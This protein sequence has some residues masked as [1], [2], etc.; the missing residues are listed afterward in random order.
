[1]IDHGP[2]ERGGSIVHS[3]GDDEPPEPLESSLDPDD[4]EA[5]DQDAEEGGS[6]EEVQES[7]EEET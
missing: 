4:L 7:S 1:M 6:S 2:R 3:V 5:G